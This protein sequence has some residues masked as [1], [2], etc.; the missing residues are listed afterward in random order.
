[1]FTFDFHRPLKACASLFGLMLVLPSLGACSAEQSNDS[2]ESGDDAPKS[3]KG[4][5]SDE[6]ALYAMTVFAPQADESYVSYLVT[7]DSLEQGTEVNPRDGIEGSMGSVA[8]IDSHPAIWAPDDQSPTATRWELSKKGVLT[9]DQTISFANLGL[10]YVDLW[11][12][13]FVSPELHVFGDASAGELVRWNPKTMEILGT[14]PLE[15][16]GSPEE[17][18]PWLAGT[19]IRPDG[20]L[21]TSWAYERFDD[22]GKVESREA[23]TVVFNKDAAEIVDRA[24]WEVPDARWMNFARA[25]LANDGTIYFQPTRVCETN[26]DGVESCGPSLVNR[27]LPGQ[28]AYDRDWEA[29]L[30]KLT[31]L[32][33][34]W[35]SSDS[36]FHVGSDRIV[37]GMVRDD[38]GHSET[39]WFVSNDAIEEAKEIAGGDFRGAGYECLIA[40]GGRLFV[41][42]WFGVHKQDFEGNTPYYEVTA[43]G[44]KPAFEVPGGVEVYNIVR[45]R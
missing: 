35:A 41:G 18:Y 43:E 20:T 25:G 7:V 15:L 36:L 23:G 19:T 34:E 11:S 1:M 37:F 26:E 17:G 8:G 44:L 24:E 28:T 4:D 3:D 13:V 16:P 38:N 40:V 29:D 32:D 39:K 9:H 42:D 6:G 10:E 5:E 33:D 30:S 14:L 2:A 21:I 12:G 22:E 27:V 31:G 45:I